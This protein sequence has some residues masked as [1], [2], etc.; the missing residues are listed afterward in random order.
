[1]TYLAFKFAHVFIA[2]VAIGSSAA[3]S[4]VLGFFVDDPAHGAFA[5]RLVRRLLWLV[6]VP[7][8]ALMLVTGM[9][10]GHLAGLLDA[11]WAEMAMDLWGFGA[12]FIALTVWAVGRQIRSFATNEP[13][14][15]AYR[16]AARW[17]RLAAAGWAV[18]IVSI[19]YF[20]VFKP[21]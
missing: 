1:M 4:I 10:M 20:M 15:V 3:L 17:S 14:S 8:Y 12:I 6:V 2:I 13:A 5:L 21:I 7:G 9:W 11:H 16:R 19:L 18:V